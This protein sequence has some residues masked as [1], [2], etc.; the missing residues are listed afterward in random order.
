MLLT[1]CHIGI[2]DNQILIL[3]FPCL[4]GD[5]VMFSWIEFQL[6]LVELWTETVEVK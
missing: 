4:R 5:R 3:D 2:F 6:N 1:N